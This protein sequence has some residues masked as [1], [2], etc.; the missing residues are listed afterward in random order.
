MMQGPRGLY[1]LT[2]MCSV[3]VYCPQRSEYAV[4]VIAWDWNGARSNWLGST[5]KQAPLP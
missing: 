3:S 1:K 2:S 5:V 4:I